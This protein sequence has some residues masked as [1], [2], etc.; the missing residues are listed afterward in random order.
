M[1]KKIKLFCS[2]FLS[3]ML[4]SCSINASASNTSVILKIVEQA[5]RRGGLRAFF[6]FAQKGESDYGEEA[7]MCPCA[8]ARDR[9][10]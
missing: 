4:F 10:Q 1:N 5:K 3:V 8:A 7:P 6:L 2:I 9:Q